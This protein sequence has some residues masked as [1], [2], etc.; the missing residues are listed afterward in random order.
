MHDFFERQDA[1][2]RLSGRLAVILAGAVLGTVLATALVMAGLATIL[3]LVQVVVTTRIELD[4]EYWIGAFADRFYLATV[5]TGV[6]VIGVVV[7]KT[8]R[9]LE[10]GGAEL[11]RQMGGTRVLTATGDP[12]YQQL[13]D[14]VE[15]LSIAT[16]L[17][18]PR[19]SYSR[20]KRASTPSRLGPNLRTRSSASRKVLWIISIAASCRVCWPTSSVTS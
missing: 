18:A 20:T 1:S 2:R 14:V 8:W 5:M 11:A 3:A 6:I 10:S 9:A 12:Q 16:G 13:I 7:Q 17:P 19:F 4:P 15:E